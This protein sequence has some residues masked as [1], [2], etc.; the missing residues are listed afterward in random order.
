M[1]AAEKGLEI[2]E[3]FSAGSKQRPAIILLMRILVVEDEVNIAHALDV[4][5]RAEGFE[6]EVENAGD[7]GLWRAREGSFDAIILDL[8]L[9]KINGYKVCAQLRSEGDQTPILMLTAKDGDFDQIEGF[10]TGADDYVTKPF[11]F[12]VLM[13]RLHALVRRGP[14]VRG[15]QLIQGDVKLDP[16]TGE[17]WRAET[18][19]ELTAREFRLLEALMVA[20]G[21]AV[22]KQELL[23]RVWGT[24]FPGSANI[25]EVYVRYLRRKVDEPFDRQ[26]I[27]TVRNIGYRLIDD[28]G[29]GR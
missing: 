7:T 5:L 6:V 8:M 24:D 19:I 10:E 28:L 11:S 9:P 18:S 22:S 14:A 23:D 15:A 12:P 20:D 1:E 21:S 16:R 26:S 2:A 13:A 29:L 27:L 3:G 4:G 17:A 25:V